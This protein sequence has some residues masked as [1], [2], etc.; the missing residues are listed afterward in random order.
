MDSATTYMYCPDTPPTGALQEQFVVH[1]EGVAAGAVVA[2]GEPFKLRSVQTGQY[3]KVVTVAAGVQQIQCNVSLAEASPLTYTS[4]GFLYNGRGIVNPG[5]SQPLY[6][7]QGPQDATSGAARPATLSTCSNGTT[8][9]YD[10]VAAGASALASPSET[11]AVIVARSGKV[12]IISHATGQPISTIASPSPCRGPFSLE[13]LPCGTL[14]LKQG[15]GSTVWSSLSCC[16]GNGCYSSKLLDNGELVVV[17]EYGE[18]VWSSTTSPSSLAVASSSSGRSMRQLQS[19][20]TTSVSCLS[21]VTQLPARLASHPGGPMLVLFGNGTLQLVSSLSSTTSAKLWQ[22]SS[23]STAVSSMLCLQP[24]NSLLLTSKRTM[25][26]TAT[27]TWGTKQQVTTAQGPFTARISAAGCIQLL[28]ASCTLIHDQCSSSGTSGPEANSTKPTPP[29]TQKPQAA[30]PQY[31][32]RPPAS[33]VM[34]R[35]APPPARNSSGSGSVALIK[36]PSTSASQPPPVTAQLDRT[37]PRPSSTTTTTTKQP[38]GRN[39]ATTAQRPPPRRTTTRTGTTRPPPHSNTTATH[40]TPRHSQQQRKQPPL[41]SSLAPGCTRPVL[42]VGA[43]CGGINM[44]GQDAPCLAGSSCCEIGTQCT[45]L[46]NFAW[47]CKL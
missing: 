6:L 36:I 8:T 44:C 5:A 13:L 3:C 47:R 34:A 41:A 19:N 37:R 20:A 2:S 1:R 31:R 21:A 7:G 35:G 42:A 9:L 18:V 43:L 11:H 46:N 45:R 27:V 28:D 16:L 14:V 25:S 33:Q 12:Q 40:P 24:D 17:D 30:S 26:S 10:T 23:S 38:P 32:R 29:R 15:N 22:L 4:A 39:S